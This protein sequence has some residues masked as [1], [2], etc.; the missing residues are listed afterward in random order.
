MAALKLFIYIVILLVIVA[1]GMLFG[2][3]ND[4]AV[5]VDL[6]FTDVSTMGIGVWILLSFVIG[7]LF[8]WLVSLPSTIGLKVSSKHHQRKIV[9]QRDELRRLKGEP[10]E[11]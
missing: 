2:F 9:R 8:G 5:T 4:T 11:G 10:S 1:L 7:S 6:L 3:R